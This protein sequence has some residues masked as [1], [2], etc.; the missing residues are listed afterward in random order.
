ME[1]WG[2]KN[3][4]K[5][6]PDDKVIPVPGMP[7]EGQEGTVTARRGKWSVGVKFAAD[8]REVSYSEN[9]LDLKAS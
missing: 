6:K 1:L 4:G 8:N 7:E 5:L 9:N 2:S 3:Y